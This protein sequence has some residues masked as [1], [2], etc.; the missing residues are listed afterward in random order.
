M[1][2]YI[3]MC[4]YV[5]IYIYTYIY[6][7]IY[8]VIPSSSRT[9][10]TYEVRITIRSCCGR[11]FG[12]IIFSSCCGSSHAPTQYA[13]VPLLHSRV[14]AATGRR[15]IDPKGALA[16]DSYEL[17]IN[18][19]SVLVVVTPLRDM[20]SCR[21]CT[22]G[23]T[24]TYICIYITLTRAVVGR[25]IPTKYVSQ[26]LVVV[27]VV[28]LNHG[29]ST[30]RSCTVALRPRQVDTILSRKVCWPQDAFY[31]RLCTYMYTHIHIYI[32]VY[33]YVY[34]YA[35]VYIYIYIYIYI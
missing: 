23:L 32:H 13:I 14:T 18:I 30:C 8:N 9:D 22:V 15:G 20:L 10:D 16:H 11:E 6:M 26:F 4:V 17:V 3:Y 34:I 31:L 12:I 19:L 21:R 33:I 2:V 1:Y 28:T 5:C 7:Y 24:H 29:L 25:M 35:F 27:V